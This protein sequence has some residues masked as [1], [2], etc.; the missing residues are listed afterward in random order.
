[1]ETNVHYPTDI[2]LLWDAMRKI[3]TLTARL[4]E[5][6]EISEWRQSKYNLRQIKRSMR[7]AQNK[8]RTKGKT[9]AQKE[10]KERLIKEAHM[11]YIE[12][13][14]HYLNKAEATLKKLEIEGLMS[15][16]DMVMCGDIKSRWIGHARRQISQIERRVIQGERIP[17]EEKVFSLFQPHTEW[18][19]KGKAGV[20]MELGLKVCIVEDQNQFILHHKVMENQTDEEIAIQITKE[21]QERF[22][23]L[24]KNSYDKGFHSPDNQKELSELLTLAV[25]PRKGKLSIAAKAIESG[26]EFVKERHQHS[27]VESAINALEVHGLDICLDHGVNGFKRYVG[28][29]IV[30]RNTQLIGAILKKKEQ[31]K[32]QRKINREIHNDTLKQA[33]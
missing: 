9:T 3:I 7:S 12:I 6:H 20:P 13:A 24:K 4:S 8:K 28:L 19:V 25:L 2:N 10:R 14:M 27:A 32:A 33:A 11:E 5:Q 15:P 16:L 1:M 18:I 26:E 31:R 21:A 17:H 30:A 29:A 23:N 22:P